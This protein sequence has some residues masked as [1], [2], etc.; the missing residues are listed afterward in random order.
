MVEGEIGAE[1]AHRQC[2]EDDGARVLRDP[3]Q[4]RLA[5]WWYRSGDQVHAD[6]SAGIIFHR[7]SRWVCRRGLSAGFPAVA[8]A[9]SF[10]AC[11]VAGFI[12][13]GW[14]C[15]TAGFDF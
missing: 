5:W 14:F 2:E 3:V 8:F 15:G 13:L 12:G 9:S 1:Q 7:A 4:A 10:G 11:F 6:G